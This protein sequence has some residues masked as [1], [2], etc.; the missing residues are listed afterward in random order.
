MVGSAPLK[1]VQD[2]PRTSILSKRLEGSVELKIF[3]RSRSHS[4]LSFY[5][6]LFMNLL[7]ISI[8]I[9]RVKSSPG[10]LSLNSA[11][12]LSAGQICLQPKRKARKTE[13]GAPSSESPEQQRIHVKTM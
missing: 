7:S 12:H 5:Y 10:F 3:Y 6:Q 9:Y 2:K 8:A 4:G 1:P 13:M 11:L